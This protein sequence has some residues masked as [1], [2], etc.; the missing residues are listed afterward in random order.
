MGALQREAGLNER[1]IPYV[2]QIA[3]EVFGQPRAVS[4]G[5]AEMEFGSK[6]ATKGNL[7]TGLWIDFSE[8][9]GGNV[10]QMFTRRLGWND[11]AAKQRCL[12]ILGEPPRQSQW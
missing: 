7:E 5:R 1:L 6:G 10:F 11:E 9:V 2:E 3:L 12:E 4:R 8:G